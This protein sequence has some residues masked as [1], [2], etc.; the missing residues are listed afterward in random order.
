[1]EG[2]LVE[3]KARWVADTNDLSA[4]FSLLHKK[5]QERLGLWKGLSQATPSPDNVTVATDL[6]EKQATLDTWWEKRQESISAQ[7]NAW[8]AELAQLLLELTAAAEREQGE[9]EMAITQMEN[10]LDGWWEKQQHSIEAQLAIWYADVVQLESR[11]VYAGTQA[12]RRIEA[13]IARMC[14]K[15]LKWQEK[16]RQSI[17]TRLDT[18]YERTERLEARMASATPEEQANLAA[19]IDELDNKYDTWFEKRYW[20]QLEFES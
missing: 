18:W 5:H 20:E 15:C 11:L 16:R 1:V 7:L 14:Q 6:S 2:K 9:A 13:D 17:D 8:A 12:K 4:T 19:R 10:E 3:V